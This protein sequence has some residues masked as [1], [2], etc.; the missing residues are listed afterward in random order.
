[1]CARAVLVVEITS[2]VLAKAVHISNCKFG[3]IL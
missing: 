1:M 3:C 2:A